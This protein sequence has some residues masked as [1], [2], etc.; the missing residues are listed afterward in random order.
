MRFFARFCAVALL[1]GLVGLA[2]CG[3]T[4]TTGGSTPV[5][6]LTPAQVGAEAQAVL[7]DLEGA[8]NVYLAANPNTPTNAV[9]NIKTAEAAAQAL[10]IQ[11]S[12]ASVSSTPAIA[13]DVVNALAAVAQAL[14][15]GVVPADVEAGVTAFQL[16]VDAIEPLVVPPSTTPV[17]APTA[18]SATKPV[19]P[20]KGLPFRVVLVPNDK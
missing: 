16:V 14:P 7:T 13:V 1:A 6:Q 5:V 20:A 8:A 15:A 11:I 10:V 4:P 9:Q 18:A 19:H 12:T 2:A 17:T 3:N